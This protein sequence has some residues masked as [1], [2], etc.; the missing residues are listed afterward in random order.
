MEKH[1][2]RKRKTKKKKVREREREREIA[3]ISNMRNNFS[4]YLQLYSLIYHRV[5][6]KLIHF[7]FACICER[8]VDILHIVAKH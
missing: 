5:H 7:E 2:E 6:I 8:A 4:G 1:N 3:K